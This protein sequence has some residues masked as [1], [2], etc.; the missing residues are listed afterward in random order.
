MMNHPMVIRQARLAAENL[1]KNVA[2]DA[3]DRIDYAYIQVLGRPPSSQERAVA[4]DLLGSAGNDGGELARWAMLYQV[5]F[6]C[7]DFRYL[8]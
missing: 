5:L 7:I 6:Q 2:P 1:R 3:R 8:D 4:V